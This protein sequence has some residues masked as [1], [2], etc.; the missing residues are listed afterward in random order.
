MIT[1][2]SCRPTA[3]TGVLAVVPIGV[4]SCADA[5]EPG[6]GTKTVLEEGD[7]TV[8]R[9]TGIDEEAARVPVRETLRIGMLEGP[10]EYLFGDITEIIPG[11]QGDVYVWDQRATALRQYDDEGNFVREIG[12]AGSGP[13]EYLHAFD[14][15]SA[16]DKVLL[17][18][19]G[20]ARINVY[21]TTGEFIA[22]E[23]DTP[24]STVAGFGLA[25]D[26]AGNVYLED[27]IDRKPAAVQMGLGGMEAV[28][29]VLGPDPGVV[30]EP[31]EAI[32][33]DGEMQTLVRLSVPFVPR[34]VLEFHRGGFFVVGSSGE[35]AITRYRAEGG[36]LRIER[37][38]DP[39]PLSS[40]LQR[41]L[42]EVVTER[43][44]RTDPDW[45]WEGP[46]LPENRDYFSAVH[47]GSDGTLWIERSVAPE[48]ELDPEGLITN[49]VQAEPEAFDVFSSDGTFCGQVVL[50]EETYLRYVE[51]STI[52]AARADDAGVPY[53]VRMA[54]GEIE[55][56]AV[57][58]VEEGTEWCGGRESTTAERGH[59]LRRTS[60]SAHPAG[61]GDG[62]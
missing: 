58:G 19:A 22:T 29:T 34:P 45:N 2:R 28:D 54:I 12:S 9:W 27:S 51:G 53:V 62:G 14:V 61:G 52:W 37:D 39:I 31:L 15:V 18:D 59:G 21:D 1:G 49:E 11:A 6:H 56:G 23:S 47:A 8:V 57:S 44:R 20:N 24:T 5:D 32:G 50:P 25:A 13:G 55:E 3:V 36:P 43:M 7:T 26:T 30:P 38:P 40:G 16:G 17:W 46:D 42:E 41:E 35:Y 4:L 33:T 60:V 48:E 10:D